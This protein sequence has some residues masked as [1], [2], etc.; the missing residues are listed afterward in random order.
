MQLLRTLRDLPP[1]LRC[2]AVSIGNFDGVHLGH[3]RIVEALRAV[4]AEVCGPA[5]VFTFDP[6]PVRLLRPDLAPPPFTWT[7]RK[8]ELLADIGVDAVI[9]YPT[10]EDL[11]QLTPDDFFG[12]IICEQLAARAMVEGPN[13]FFGRDRAGDIHKLRALCDAHDVRLTI[14]DPTKYGSD[15]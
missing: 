12:R 10:D 1:A 4:A 3:A 13:F 8:A 5:I 15:G 9:A 7:D 2:G 11:L 14:V 6:H